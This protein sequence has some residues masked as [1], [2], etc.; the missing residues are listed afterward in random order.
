M[1]VECKL[2]ILFKNGVEK[3]ITIIISEEDMD[4]LVMSLKN[5]VI[6]SKTKTLQLDG[7]FINTHEIVYVEFMNIRETE[8]VVLGM[9]IKNDSE[10]DNIK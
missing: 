9:Y 6:G 1:M 8:T 7:M 3:C 10:E 5:G 2:K 4:N